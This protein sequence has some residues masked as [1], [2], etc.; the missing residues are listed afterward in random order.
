MRTQYDPI[1]QKVEDFLGQHH[2]RRRLLRQ[3][4]PAQ[5]DSLDTSQEL[6]AVAIRWARETED[7]PL[8]FAVIDDVNQ[9]KTLIRQSEE[10]IEKLNALIGASN[11]VRAFP[12]LLAG[13]ELA[14]GLIN[15]ISKARLEI[16]KG[17]DAEEPG[18][19]SGDIGAAH[20][21]RKKLEA[22]ISGLPVSSADF[23]ERDQ[24]GKQQWNAV[25]QRL[26]Q[27]MQEI[28]QLQAVVNGLRRM[29]K[30]GPRRGVTRDPDSIKRFNAEIDENERLL[31]QH[32]E[33]SR[34]LASPDRGRPRADRPR[35]RALSG[36]RDEPRV[37][38][39][40][41]RPRGAARRKAAPRVATRR[42]TRAR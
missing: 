30:E 16:A 13:E 31:K 6:P 36:R 20:E 34:D 8:A 38:P 39:R 14:L 21:Q 18:S 32:R 9:C 3:A 24:Q 15:R 4:Q 28:D 11:R 42:S 5:L 10:L 40:R 41:A 19:L 33:E 2:R 1:R 17:L 37:V 29:I 7:G 12:E 23:A 25:S 22:D 26:T 35:R 27:S